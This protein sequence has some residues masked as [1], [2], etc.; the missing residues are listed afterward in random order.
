MDYKISAMEK[1]KDTVKY[2]I[3]FTLTKTNNEWQLDPLSNTDIEK[4]HGIYTG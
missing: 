3:E 2:T 4:L 1:V